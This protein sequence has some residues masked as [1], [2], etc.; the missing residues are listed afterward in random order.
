MK[1]TTKQEYNS[2]IAYEGTKPDKHKGQFKK[3]IKR[4][5]SKARRRAYKNNF[6]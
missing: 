5:V 1:P 6:N 2:L 3:K 4:L